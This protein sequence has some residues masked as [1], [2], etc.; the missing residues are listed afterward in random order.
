MTQYAGHYWNGYYWTPQVHSGFAITG[1]VLGLLSFFSGLWPVAGIF[2][3]LI[4]FGF[5]MHARINARQDP[6]RRY[7]TGLAT[8]GAWLSGI[9][10]VSYIVII[11]V[12]IVTG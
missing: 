4:G 5:S 11:T 6:W 10:F 12:R 1:F 2:L 3:S 9:T 8:A 7:K